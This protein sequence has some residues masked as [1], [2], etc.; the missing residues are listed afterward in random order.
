MKLLIY[1]TPD[2]F[3]GQD[4]SRL[5]AKLS[6]GSSVLA[7]AASL[8][9]HKPSADSAGVAGSIPI[10]RNLYEL[11]IVSACILRYIQLIILIPYYLFVKFF[12]AIIICNRYSVNNLVCKWSANSEDSC[13][14]TKYAR[15][16]RHSCP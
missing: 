16:H 1:I 9:V 5:L 6:P 10:N 7:P 12:L 14:K 8:S 11:M 15:P 13:G 3:S 4:F 2:A